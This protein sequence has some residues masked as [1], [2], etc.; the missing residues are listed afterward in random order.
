MPC[1]TLAPKARLLHAMPFF[2]GFDLFPVA[3]H[4][5]GRALDVRVHIGVVACRARSLVAKDVRMAAH[6]LAIQM[7][8]HIGDG[9]VALV[10]GHLRIEEH[11]QAADRRVPQAGARSRGARWRRRPRRPLRACICGWNR[12]ICSRSQGQPPGARRRAMMATDCSN[13]LCRPRRIGDGLRRGIVCTGALWRK[14]HA[15]PV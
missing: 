13:K 4:G 1:G 11:L 5:G 3:Q 15:V 10:G 12:R 6:Q 9:E 8:E 2:G 14:I 7:V